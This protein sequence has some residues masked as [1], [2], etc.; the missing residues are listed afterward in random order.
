[1]D[2]ARLPSAWMCVM[3]ELTSVWGFNLA[4]PVNSTTT[5]VLSLTIPTIKIMLLSRNAAR[6]ALNGVKKIVLVQLP[7]RI[8]SSLKQLPQPKLKQLL[9]LLSSFLSV[10]NSYH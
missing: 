8:V 5:L 2:Q 7:T 3:A 4:T 1:M 10:G 6:R 9:Q